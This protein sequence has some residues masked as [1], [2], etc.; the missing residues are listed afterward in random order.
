MYHSI[1]A[2]NANKITMNIIEKSKKHGYKKLRS[3]VGF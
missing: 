2:Y 3:R 1:T